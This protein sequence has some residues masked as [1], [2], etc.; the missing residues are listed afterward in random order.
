MNIVEMRPRKLVLQKHSPLL[1]LHFGLLK[2][3]GKTACYIYH[4]NT[5]FILNV[6]LSSKKYFTFFFFPVLKIYYP[7]LWILVYHLFTL[8][9]TTDCNSYIY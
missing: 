6:Y 1:F 7:A 8:L 4:W 3:T 9:C 5:Y 2:G